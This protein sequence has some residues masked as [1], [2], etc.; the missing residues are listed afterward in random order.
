VPVLAGPNNYGAGV[1]SVPLYAQSGPLYRTRII[2]YEGATSPNLDPNPPPDPCKA[3]PG[4]NPLD[5]PLCFPY[6]VV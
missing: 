6:T 4:V 1:G 2:G 3:A 5:N